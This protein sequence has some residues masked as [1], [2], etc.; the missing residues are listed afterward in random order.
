MIRDIDKSYFDV[1]G[2][3]LNA[4]SQMRAYNLLLDVQDSQKFLNIFR[5]FNIKELDNDYLV[6]YEMG[7]DEWWDNIAYNNYGT[8][9]LWWVIPLINGFVNPFEIPEAGTNIQI[10]KEEYL[11]LLLNEWKGLSEK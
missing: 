10:L 2:I 3:S 6:T 5:S 7:Y 8:P 4:N 11:Y 9:V 1:T